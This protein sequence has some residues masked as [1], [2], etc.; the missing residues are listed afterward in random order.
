MGSLRVKGI[1]KGPAGQG[2]EVSFTYDVNGILEVE[3]RVA[4]TEKFVRKLFTRDSRTLSEDALQRAAARIRK[5]KDDP[6]KKIEYRD[7][8][9][10]A[11][12]LWK[13]LPPEGRSM[14]ADAIGDFES[15]IAGRNPDEVRTAY[16]TLFEVC[17]QIDGGDRW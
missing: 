8:M 2:V 7:L 5:L 1:P 16:S 4:G 15:A 17:E 12:L 9:L 11:E 6:L 13:D 10:R 14:L 3:A